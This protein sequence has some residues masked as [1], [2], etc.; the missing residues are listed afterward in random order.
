MRTVIAHL[1]FGILY[2]CY[3]T[4]SPPAGERGGEYGPLNHRFPFTPVELR[5]GWGLGEER[6]L[7][8]VSGT[9]P[10]PH[11]AEPRVLLFDSRGREKPADAELR[12]DGDAWRVTVTLE[13]W[14]EVAVVLPGET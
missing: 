1:R 7:T 11:A 12:R 4:D 9:F 13:D 3:G 2:D 14:W 8:C 6:L 5:E 10:W